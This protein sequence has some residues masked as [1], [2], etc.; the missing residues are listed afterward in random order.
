ML[1]VIILSVMILNDT[2][3][4]NVKLDLNLRVITLSV[5][6][7]S[8]YA[9]CYYAKCHYAKCH[10]VERRGTKKFAIVLNVTMR[11]GLFCL[12][13]ATTKAQ[14]TFCQLPIL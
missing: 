9:Q 2:N 1:S 10:Y 14:K 6:M 4:S 5:I 8:H 12:P 7:N 13:A 3:K 11:C